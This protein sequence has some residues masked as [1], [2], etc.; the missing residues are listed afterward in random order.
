[1][2]IHQDYSLAALFL[3]SPLQ[4]VALRLV[5]E[6]PSA[7]ENRSEFA[8]RSPDLWRGQRSASADADAAASVDDHTLEDIGARLF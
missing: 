1:M 8:W 7:S 2:L 3:R 6:R 4:C 5:G